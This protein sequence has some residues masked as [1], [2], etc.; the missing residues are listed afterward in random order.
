[1]WDDESEFTSSQLTENILSLYGYKTWETDKIDYKIS[2]NA[3]Q[4]SYDIFDVNSRYFDSVLN[5]FF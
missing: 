4:Y 5:D 1:M 2:L 3:N